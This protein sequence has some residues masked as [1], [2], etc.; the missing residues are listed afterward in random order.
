MF[1]RFLHWSNSV[2]RIFI[3]ILSFYIV[4]INYFSNFAE[5]ITEIVTFQL[6][7]DVTD[8]L[9]DPSSPARK[10]IRECLASKLT[11]KGARHAYFGQFLEKPKMAI[12]FVV[13]DSIQDYRNL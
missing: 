5:M 12:I 8:N 1:V 10:V 7:A 6:N 4:G 3:L 9:V 13:W 2:S 11:A